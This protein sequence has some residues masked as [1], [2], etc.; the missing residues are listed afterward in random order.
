MQ[1]MVVT[2]ERA[3]MAPADRLREIARRCQ[4]G[5]P[6]DPAQ[7]SWL[8]AALDS[9]LD[10][11]ADS[12]EHALGLRY[13]R[14]GVP[15]WRESA[16]RRR[17]SA[18]RALADEF[19][20]EHST[21]ARSREIARLAERYAAT[22]WRFDRKEPEMPSHYAGTMKEYLWHAFK[23]GATMPLGERQLRNIVGN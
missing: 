11:A 2:Q 9:Y 17:D 23:S 22:A 21:C 14:G 18:L 4:A 19:L 5:E 16:L 3:H 12:L 15:W 20:A 1:G 13:G 7:S 8:A 6:L 10:K